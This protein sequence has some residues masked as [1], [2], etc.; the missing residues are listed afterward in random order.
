[1]RENH[2]EHQ[3]FSQACG[4]IFMP[5]ISTTSR[6][7]D[8]RLFKWSRS[9]TFYNQNTSGDRSG[10]FMTFRNQNMIFNCMG[11]FPFYQNQ[12]L[13]ELIPPI[14]YSRTFLVLT[15]C[16]H[17]AVRV[18]NAAL[19]FYTEAS[20]TESTMQTELSTVQ[21]QPGAFRKPCEGQAPLTALGPRPLKVGQT[22]IIISLY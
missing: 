10:L 16:T 15:V 8:P 17:Q 1:M 20:R 19:W 3:R 7:R 14:H 4:S 18:W 22:K 6:P 12:I 9:L 2:P 5:H 11:G 13:I 21:L